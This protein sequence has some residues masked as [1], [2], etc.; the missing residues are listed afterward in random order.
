MSDLRWLSLSKPR[1]GVE[2]TGG[3]GVS[4]WQKGDQ[5]G[6][7]WDRVFYDNSIPRAAL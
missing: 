5:G 2:T 7:D 3:V 1:I 6:F 4:L